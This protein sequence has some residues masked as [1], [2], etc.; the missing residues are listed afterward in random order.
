MSRPPSGRMKTLSQHFPGPQ[1]SLLGPYARVLH[2]DFAVP[3]FGA[4]KIK[5]CVVSR[6]VSVIFAGQHHCGLVAVGRGF[7]R[8]HGEHLRISGRDSPEPSTRRRGRRRTASGHRRPRVC[9]VGDARLPL[10]EQDAT[11]HLALRARIPRFQP[12]RTGRVRRAA[13][14][15]FLFERTGIQAVQ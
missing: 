2:H 13:T 15:L 6:R 5:R 4:N 8:A 9:A 1:S 7:A 10:D 3:S 14:A 11:R 12:L